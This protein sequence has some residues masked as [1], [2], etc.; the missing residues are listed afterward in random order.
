MPHNDLPRALS[1]RAPAIAF[2]LLLSSFGFGLPAAAAIP[3]DPS[4]V[5]LETRLREA[6]FFEEPLVATGPSSIEEQ[7]ALWEAIQKFRDGRGAEAFEPLQAFLDQY[8]GS[9]WSLALRTN[10]G[11]AYYHLGYFS[12]A[13]DAWEAAWRDTRAQAQ[14]ETKR[15][16]DRALGELIRMHAR[17][18]HADRVN[19]LLK[20]AESRPLQG[21]A[22]EAVAGA[23]EGLWVMRH[24]P[25]VAYLCGPM[26]LKSILQFQGAD[27]S[28]I[29]KINAVRSSPSGV[30]L[31][32]VGQ[33][34]K[35]VNLKYTIAKRSPGTPIPLPAV[36]H[37]KINHYAAIVGEQSGRYHLKDPT[38]GQDLW[39]SKDALEAETSNYFLIPRQAAKQ[40][41]WKTVAQ[42]EA[43]KVFGMGYTQFSDPARTRPNDQKACDCK[44]PSPD[45]DNAGDAG[46]DTPSVGMPTYNVHAMLVSLNFVDTPISYRPPKG[47]PVNFTLTYNQ[48]EA[49]QPANFSY[50]NFGQKWTSN[51]LAY[52]QDNPM[53]PGGNV[54]RIVAGGGAVWESGAYNSSTGAFGADPQDMS[55]LVRTSATSYERRMKD[56]SK[57]VYSQPDGATSYPRAIFLSQLI[58]PQGNAVSLGYDSRRRLTT[59]TDAL[60]KQ[61]ALSYDNASDPLLVT[62]ITDPFGRTAK[63]GYDATG[64]LSDITDAVGMKSSFSYDAGTFIKAMTTPYGTTQFAYGENGVQRWVNITD[65][66]GQTERVEYL[67]EAAGIP[68]SEAL[69]PAGM[70]LFNQYVN[71]RNTY[72]WNAK[73][74]AEAAGDYTKARITHWLHAYDN[75]N[76]TAGVIESTKEPLENR[77]WYNYLNQPWNG[78]AGTS[79]LP[80]AIG[81][82]QDDGS[83]QLTQYAYNAQGNRT[84][85]VDPL[86]TQTQYEYAD[87]GID[88]VRVTQSSTTAFALLA[89]Y[90]YD[91]Q[92]RPLAYRDAA[93]QVT[94]YTYN[95]AGQ[96]ASETDPL[97]NTKRWEYDDSGFLQRIVNAAGKTEASYTY[98]GVGRIANW[99]DATGYTLSYQYDALNRLTQTRY[100][101]GTTSL[102]TWDKLDLVSVT[103]RL[104]RVTSYAYDSVRNRIQATDS[105]G[106]STQYAFYPNGKIKTVTEPNGRV[107]T[108]T[109]TASGRLADQTAKTADGA[110][111]TTSYSYDGI[112][113][114]SRVARSDGS[115]TTLQYDKAG[116]MIGATDTLGNSVAYALDSNGNRSQEQVKDPNGAVTMQTSRVFDSMSRL[117]QV[118]QGASNS[119]GS[120][121]DAGSLV[122]IH[123]V[124]ITA[125]G[126]YDTPYTPEM[127]LD[128]NADTRWTAT[129]PMQWI[130]VDLGAP[131][132]L[133]AMRMLTAQ[134]SPSDPNPSGRTTHV[135]TAGSAPAPTDEMQTV[136]GTT[137]DHQ[138]LVVTPRLGTS[139]VRYVRIT[140]SVSPFWVS[141]RELEFYK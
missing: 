2:T 71:D 37:W 27:S 51:W 122:K 14:P 132:A 114:L 102:Q 113:R 46:A 133:R 64:R 65:P 75:A 88:L 67:H 29:A 77:V 23:R 108:S 44:N 18:G 107:T 135:V 42:A 33:L 124:G 103:D 8:P 9:P 11:L 3:T 101:D 6:R 66:L 32:T 59:I 141:W 126:Y 128:G 52:I 4:T 140:T 70:N 41:G 45:D 119:T 94:T 84:S 110:I 85:K 82:V 55:V 93:G 25:G 98:D 38:F 5:A 31:D 61:T 22:T 138:W 95:A 56:G 137:W 90:T 17:I 12:R 111:Q 139:P 117:R 49:Y 39:I 28:R 125:S 69:A 16:A 80:I 57:E 36:V 26:A 43:K 78:A 92:H 136:S 91:A 54:R 10:M 96:K 105:L 13:I 130:E 20:E 134:M 87:N 116:R 47:P 99:T 50:F 127:V 123:P 72:Y 53:Y 63:L 97:G 129:Y 60:G 48:R 86:G 19:A 62:K 131:V 40:A 109:Y 1:V 34:A 58:D 100:P 83:T 24:D 68:F 30:T 73:A 106:R 112:G 81:R 35:Q 7:Q 79:E 21:A 115:Y 74:Y 15:L 76:Y 104:G 120:P 89:E 118:T 121:L